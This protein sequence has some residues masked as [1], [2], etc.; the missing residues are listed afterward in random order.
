[1]KVLVEGLERARVEKYSDRVEYYEA[2]AVALADTDANSV[3]AEAQ[4]E[5]GVAGD[6]IEDRDVM[7]RSR[8]VV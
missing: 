1:M 6:E 2:T 3:E 5:I 7:V 4:A 8:W